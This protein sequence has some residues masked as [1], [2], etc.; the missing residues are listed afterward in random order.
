MPHP[1]EVARFQVKVIASFKA[2]LRK[3]EAKVKFY[4]NLL[5]TRPDDLGVEFAIK[6]HEREVRMYKELIASTKK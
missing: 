4:K 2:N 5:K 1:L 6:H 3:A